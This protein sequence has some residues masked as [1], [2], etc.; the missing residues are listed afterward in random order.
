MKTVAAV[1]TSRAA[2][3]QAAQN[4]S[5]VGIPTEHI[6]VLSPDGIDQQAEKVPVTPAEQPGMGGAFGGVVGGAVGIAGGVQLGT[7]AASIAI[8][9]VGPVIAIGLFGAAIMGATGVM[10]GMQIGKKLDDSLSEGLPE[11]ELYVYKDALRR[12]HSVVIAL[13]EDDWQARE[14]R[15]ACAQAGAESVDQA[16]QDV[17]LGLRDVRAEKYDDPEGHDGRPLSEQSTSKQPS[18]ERRSS[19]R[20]SSEDVKKQRKAS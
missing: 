12:G 6:S 9:G 2:A 8:P 20:P 1:F 15:R 10:A 13:A 7:A 16:R 19:E 3:Q 11:D 14:A 18:A 4:L 17:W 5:G